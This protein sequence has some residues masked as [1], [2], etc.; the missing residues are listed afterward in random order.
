MQ[1]TKTNP[2][3]SVS[4]RAYN[5][6]KFIARAIE[7]VLA[8]N[9]NFDY[10]IVIGEDCSPDN[11][12]KIVINFQKRYPDKIRLLL[13]GKNIGRRKNFIQ[14]LKACRGK[15]VAL[16]D[17][18]DYWSAPHKL[19]KQV[20]FLDSHSACSSC[21]HKV[22]KVNE[23][24]IETPP[25]RKRKLKPMLTME[26]LLRRN[27]IQTCSVVFRN[28]LFDEFPKWL[29]HLFF[30]D[31]PLHIMNTQHGDI[32][33][34]D[35]VMGA[36]RTYSGGVRTYGHTLPS[37]ER[38]KYCKED[39]KFYKIINRYLKY[40]YNT[41]IKTEIVKRIIRKGIAQIKLAFIYVLPGVYRLYR[42][43]RY[44]S[45]STFPIKTWLKSL[46]VYPLYRLLTGKIRVRRYKAKLL[47]P[48]LPE[49][50]VIGLHNQCTRKCH[51]CRFGLKKY[52]N[53][54]SHSMPDAMITKIIDELKSINYKNCVEIARYNEPMIDKRLASIIDMISANLP[55]CK[56][57]IV[58]NG[59]LATQEKLERLCKTLTLHRIWISVYDS[60][61]EFINRQKMINACN[62]Q[63][64]TK[65]KL[66]RKFSFKKF[67]VVNK[68]GELSIVPKYRLKEWGSILKPGLI[69]TEISRRLIINHDGTVPMCCNILDFADE[70]YIMG[71]LNTQSIME[72]WKGEK[73]NVIRS[74]M[75]Q[76]GLPGIDSCNKCDDYRHCL[77]SSITKA[78]C[79]SISQY[80]KR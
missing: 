52:A 62:E 47:D 41:I 40:K 60:E 5:H 32:G 45:D 27:F 43:L 73:F 76:K 54:P 29:N 55:E 10:E 70:E 3:V 25:R 65:V 53:E 46:P 68:T 61:E 34:I 8:Q 7:S 49:M 66:C 18:D 4:M 36:F 1:Y 14:T 51:F 71:N 59:D 21:F 58:T 30:L 38:V 9:V 50:I 31:W 35:E 77:A 42:R 23:N 57:S 64:R 15:Y 78:A 26:D 72:I 33:Y 80:V 74:K 20:D 17:G 67:H 48:G 28:G 22:N 39:I 75:L 16:L 63:V 11:T 19:Q 37:F 6:E 69:C 79:S 13:P 2:K 24:G 56:I 12:R 44:G